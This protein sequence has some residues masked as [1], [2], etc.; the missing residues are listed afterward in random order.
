MNRPV[1]LSAPRYV[2]GE[3]DE[4][5]TT[6]PQLA[7]RARR[8]R[9]QPSA[10][11]WGWGTVRRTRRSREELAVDTGLATLHGAG[12]DPLSVDALVLCCTRFPGG[13]DRHGRFTGTVMSGLGLTRAAFTGITLNR[14]TNLLAAIDVADA[15][16]ASGRHRSVLVVTTDRVLDETQRL[17]NFALFSDGAASCL[18]T[19]EYRTPD[20]YE[21]LGCASAQNAAELDWSS[22]LSADLAREVND[23][24]LK[25]LGLRLGQISGLLHTNLFLPLL[26]MKERLAGFGAEQLYTDNVRRIGHCFAADPLINLVDRAAAGHL[27]PDHYYLLAGSVPGSRLGVLLRA[28]P[29]DRPP[30]GP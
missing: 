1:Y 26:V 14:C 9:M 18:V 12:V 6:V 22:Q 10:E 24:L 11:L 13:A 27:R 23:S 2:L 20:S 28:L 21:I 17:E 29:A 15:F 25:P 4:D 19:A 7:E 8:F 16:V 5:H 30:T 3:I